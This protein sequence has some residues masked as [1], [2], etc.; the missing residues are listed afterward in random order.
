MWNVIQQRAALI[1]EPN[2]V[3]ILRVV[4]DAGEISRIEIAKVTGL[5]KTTITDLVGKLIRAGFLEETG[6]VESR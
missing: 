1:R 6:A 4:R 3:R 5:H 2:E